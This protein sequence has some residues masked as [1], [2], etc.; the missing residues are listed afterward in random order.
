M[1]TCT[2]MGVFALVAILTFAGITQGQDEIILE[3]VSEDTLDGNPGYMQ[4]MEIYGTGWETD[5]LFEENGFIRWYAFKM[6]WE[7]TF[8]VLPESSYIVR[9]DE[10]EIGDTWNSWAYEPT[11]AE[12]VDTAT[13]TVPAGTFFTYRIE[14]QRVGRPTDLVSIQWLALDVGMVKVDLE[15][16]TASLCEFQKTGGAGFYP[17]CVGNRWTLGPFAEG[18]DEDSDGGSWENDV[19]ASPFCHLSQNH[20]NPFN[21]TTT[22][23]YSLSR[24]ANVILT[25]FDVRGG[26]VERLVNGYRHAGAHAV[27]WNATDIGSGVYLYRIECDD[28]SDVKKCMV[29][30]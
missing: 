30:K 3:I 24:G 25:I 16:Y 17:L 22:F 7:Q 26:V 21:P 14:H 18:V 28:F 20:P 11:I 29:M 9:T 4:E 12:V 5:F 6:S 1:K 10:L 27:T 15:I 2:T 8:T 23:H 19:P 13:V